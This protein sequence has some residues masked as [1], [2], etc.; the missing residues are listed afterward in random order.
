M[1][2]RRAILVRIRSGDVTLAFR[3][4]RRPTVKTGSTL[5]TAVDL[6]VIQC[7]EK[8]NTRNISETDT[9]RAGYSDRDALIKEL[10]SREGDFTRS[11]SPTQAKIPRIQLCRDDKLSESEF[12]EIR[13]SLQ[14]LDSTSQVVSWTRLVLMATKDIRCCPP[15]S[16][17]LQPD[18]RKSGSNITCENSRILGLR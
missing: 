10:S 7:V 12:T 9:H 17:R 3:R 16:L 13:E 6:L 4:W 2:I 8:T 15:H 1:L 5:K 14:R 18:L 11:P